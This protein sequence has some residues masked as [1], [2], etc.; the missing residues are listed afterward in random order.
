VVDD[1]STYDNEEYVYDK[2]IICDDNAW[3]AF[4]NV[5]SNSRVATRSI[6][7]SSKI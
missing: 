7:Y 4:G 5:S 2:L 1:L 3:R 6:L